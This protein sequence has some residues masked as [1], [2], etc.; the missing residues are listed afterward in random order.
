MPAKPADSFKLRFGPYAVPKTRRGAKLFCEIRGTMTVGRYSDGPIPWPR[1]K[2]GG[3]ACLILCGS[4]VRAV[5]RE[6][7]I[8]VAHHWGVS[9]TTVWKWR[10][11]LGV[12]RW[13]AGS[14][15][16][17]RDWAAGRDDDRFERAWANSQRP[18]VFRRRSKAMKRQ[19]LSEPLRRAAAKAAK[20]PRSRA[21]CEAMSKAMKKNGHVPPGLPDRPRWTPEEEALLGTDRNAVIALRVDRS[22]RAV[23]AHRVV[24]GLPGSLAAVDGRAIERLRVA[25]GWSRPKLAERAGVKYETVWEIETGRRERTD[26]G[27]LDR[28]AAA[29][30]AP[31]LSIEDG[32]QAARRGDR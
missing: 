18:E 32:G 5:K 8:A 30:G 14:T 20:R 24:M 1:V 13:N 17:A 25:K 11:I 29:L 27:V 15:D 2:K 26:R 28:I 10:K 31:A 7:L 3:G 9:L 22:E 12:E 16:L 23:R 6:A 4:L 19:P 21:W